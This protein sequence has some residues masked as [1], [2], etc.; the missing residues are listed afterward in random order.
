MM[1]LYTLP[2]KMHIFLIPSS[3][4]YPMTM[5]ILLDNVLYIFITQQLQFIRLSVNSVRVK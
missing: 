2:Y 3:L 4:K 1:I 5:S